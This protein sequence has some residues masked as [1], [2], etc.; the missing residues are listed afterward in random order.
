M[1]SALDRPNY[2]PRQPGLAQPRFCPLAH[3]CT[4]AE[5]GQGGR[6]RP[7]C[8]ATKLRPLTDHIRHAGEPPLKRAHLLR[9][10]TAN[11]VCQHAHDRSR[12]A[13]CP[14]VQQAAHLRRLASRHVK[15]TCART[16]SPRNQEQAR[17][18]ANWA[19]AV[20]EFRPAGTL[21]TLKRASLSQPSQLFVN[22]HPQVEVSTQV[23]T[24][25]ATCGYSGRELVWCASTSGRPPHH[26][27]SV[28]RRKTRAASYNARW[29]LRCVP[30]G[31]TRISEVHR[32]ACKLGCSNTEAAWHVG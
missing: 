31:W 26:P 10:T 24:R 32:T 6:L 11:A 19:A 18:V 1:R 3:Q 22:V 12:H 16:G 9:R 29:L 27:I 21:C 20:L 28:L 7:P 13:R 5:A 8:P 4:R 30:R 14:R 15:C 25:T 23:C 2:P 17:A